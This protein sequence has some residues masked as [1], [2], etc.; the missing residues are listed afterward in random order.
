[1]NYSSLNFSGF[2]FICPISQSL[3]PGRAVTI[4]PQ[5]Q[6]VMIITS[7]NSVNS[8]NIASNF[9]ASDFANLT[10][11]FDMGD[12]RQVCR[13]DLRRTRC[14]VLTDSGYIQTIWSSGKISKIA[15]RFE[16]G[17]KLS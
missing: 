2:Q 6:E 14:F 16:N 3:I 17:N 10:V 5:A 1:L 13:G 11:S 15:L 7:F 9:E 8:F 12:I 4:V